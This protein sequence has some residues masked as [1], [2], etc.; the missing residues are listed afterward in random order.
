MKLCS[1]SDI[2]VKAAPCFLQLLRSLKECMK[3][4][5]KR[6]HVSDDIKVEGGGRGWSLSFDFININ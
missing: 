1:F 2:T 6:T 4:K 5:R 3:A